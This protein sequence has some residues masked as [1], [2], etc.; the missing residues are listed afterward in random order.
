MKFL[1]LVSYYC[2]LTSISSGQSLSGTWQ[3]KISGGNSSIRFILHL[4]QDLG[5]WTASFDSPDQGA[6]GIRGGDPIVKLDS[7]FI[8]IP[9]LGASFKGKWD[10]ANSITG[11]FQQGPMEVPLPLERSTSLSNSQIIPL[12]RPQTPTTPFNYISEDV[13]F[14]SK[15]Q[16]TQF[17]GSLT[18]QPKVN[19]QPALIII[20]GSGKQDRDGTIFDHKPYLVLADYLTRNGYVVLRV[21]DRG[22]G[23]STAGET[24]E[25]T[26]ESLSYD[27][28]AALDYLL[29][30]TDIDQ[31][32]I[33]LIGHSEGGVIA[34]KIA[35]RRKEIAAIILWGA[36]ATGG[37]VINT[38]QNAYALRNAGVDSIAVQSFIQL[39]S[40]VLAI[41]SQTTKDS[42]NSKVEKIFQAWKGQ[43]TDPV[44]KS[45]GVADYSIVGLNI[46]DL[47]HSLYDIPWM[48]Y[49]LTYEPA[50]D[51]VKVKCPVLAINGTK[52]TQVPAE[53]NLR[54]IADVLKRSGNQDVTILPLLNLNHFL[55]TAVTGDISEYSLIE[56]TISK[57]ALIQIIEWLNKKL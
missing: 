10:Q 41:F 40:N 57:T 43:Q 56:E 19:R 28:E 32:R 45:L 4:Q 13:Q 34:M 14:S 50:T 27:T 22:V 24:T 7:V 26:T 21:D 48:Y 9:E 15:D 49:T 55:Q 52:D 3:G 38:Q 25:V 42:L 53:D 46:F 18:K 8:S 6:F 47:Y 44:L 37:K 20:S 29:S 5:K 36:P 11:V 51:L 2:L 35:A 12:N 30:R 31:N 39:H 1:L 23:K 17:A 33:G 16:S 54:L